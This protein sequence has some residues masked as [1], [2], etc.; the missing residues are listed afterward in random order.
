MDRRL[1]AG[2]VVVAALVLAGLAAGLLDPLVATDGYQ[3]TDGE[4]TAT[5]LSYEHTTVTV[6]DAETGEQLGQVRAAI[7]DT[8][9]KKYTGLSKT[10]SLPEDRGMLFPY[11][12]EGSHTYVMRGMSFGI[13]IIYVGADGTITRIHHAPEPPEGADGDTYE[14]PGTGKYVLEVNYNWTVR[15]NVTE[16]DQVQ[17]GDT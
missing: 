6:V 17:I 16:G 15:H 3:P 5:P 8:W 1:V 12:S 7:A 13:D 9:R 11:E 4:A 14:Y 2:V 10:A